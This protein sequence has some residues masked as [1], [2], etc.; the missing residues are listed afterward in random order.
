MQLYT[1][2]HDG[3]LPEAWDNTRAWAEILGA[4]GVVPDMSIGQNFSLYHCPTWLVK[5]PVQQPRFR[6]YGLAIDEETVAA[7]FNQR[8]SNL[9]PSSVL[10][11]DSILAPPTDPA[12]GGGEEFYY[13][14]RKTFT[15]KEVHRRHKNKAN[16][17]FVDGHAAALGEQ[18]VIDS[19]IVR[20][21]NYG[22][23]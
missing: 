6:T 12:L 22:N 13:I 20:S 2:D 1:D 15:F 17:V 4:S 5:N 3:F 9:S 23:Q 18:E 8:I 16:A 10:L 11:A 21:S 7:I 14:T 19:G